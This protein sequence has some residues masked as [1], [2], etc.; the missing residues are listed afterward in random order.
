MAPLPPVRKRTDYSDV[1]QDDLTF[2]LYHDQIMGVGNMRE[3]AEN[4][5]HDLLATKAQ[6]PEDR[7]MFAKM[8][9]GSG[10]GSGKGGKGGGGS[11]LWPKGPNGKRT[12]QAAA[13][14]SRGDGKGT[15][16]GGSGTG[17]AKPKTDDLPQDLRNLTPAQHRKVVDD[18]SKMPLTE[19]RKR[20]E[21]T[22]EQQRTAYDDYQ[23]HG[24]TTANERGMANLQVRDQHLAAAI[25]KQTFGTRPDAPAPK[26]PRAG[27]P[28][29]R[30]SEA[31]TRAG[32]PVAALP[33]SPGTADDFHGGRE[34]V[35]ARLST[36]PK[37]ELRAMRD[38]VKQHNTPR[39]NY[40]TSGDR[41]Y[42]KEVITYQQ[43]LI[44]A[45]IRQS[46][47][48]EAPASFRVFKDA[49]GQHRWVAVSS[50]AYRDRDG[51]IVSTKAL[52]DD[53]A[54]ADQSGQYG[55]LRWWH[56]PG[57]DLGDCDFNAMSG[58]VLIES[59]TF[60]SPEIAQKVA[61]AAD[62]HG[63]E[64]SLGFFHPPSEPDAGGV[65]HTI[66][67][68][69]RS[70]TPRGKASNLFTSFTVKETQTMLD[71]KQ[72]TL[73]EIGFTDAEIATILA[74]AQQK[75]KSAD[76]Q[77]IAYKADEPEDSTGPM[78]GERFKDYNGREYVR[79]PSEFDPTGMYYAVKAAPPPF[80]GSP[81]EE[82][83]ETADEAMAEGDDT[84]ESDPNALT[85]S[86]GDMQ[87]IGELIAQSLAPLA[88]LMEMEK[89]MA[90]HV[91]T[92]LAPFQQAQA[93]KDATAAEQAQRIT[94]LETSLKEAKNELAALTGDQPAVSYRAT[95][96]RDNVVGT[97]Q[98]G[99]LIQTVKEQL[100]STPGQFDDIISGLGLKIV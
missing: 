6:T 22:R 2:A 9:G 65:F 20:Q 56:M 63:L 97:L 31:A 66:K 26:A 92:A 94:Q 60:R 91:Q 81:E 82:S 48:K 59:G 1:K 80:E 32:L 49:R 50:T 18:L 53:C 55:P 71:I 41:R 87:A 5:A 90:G 38:D 62:Q 78:P 7:A 58:R 44:D 14:Q 36:L 12:P 99:Q 69:E 42:S 27:T 73:K 24:A 13:A 25:N 40:V 11:K 45:A 8:G 74:D 17:D 68:F 96:A 35:I 4:P 61:R 67:R 57:M 47:T 89:K 75:Q 54:R 33:I 21:L 51:E 64:I 100:P 95:A 23:K 52:A 15:P 43:S 70:L 19:L 83:S 79:S 88:G 98:D 93:T 10:G 37:S 30:L 86:P 34:N 76:D 46:K 39:G 28:G 3:S 77:G 85:L 72:R 84:G 29:D 16:K